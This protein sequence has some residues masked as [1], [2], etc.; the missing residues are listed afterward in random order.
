MTPVIK[1]ESFSN[2]SILNNPD[3]SLIQDDLN[4]LHRLNNTTIQK[5]NDMNKLQNYLNQFKD[6]KLAIR[7]DSSLAYSALTEILDKYDISLIADSEFPDHLYQRPY[8]VVDEDAYVYSYKNMDEVYCFRNIYD[9]VDI[10]ELECLDMLQDFKDGKL[11]VQLINSYQYEKFISYLKENGIAI[12]SAMEYTQNPSHF[13]YFYMLRPG[14][15]T[16]GESYK[17]IQDYVHI[18]KLVPLG[19]FMPAFEKTMKEVNKVKEIQPNDFA[20]FTSGRLVVHINNSMEHRLFIDYLKEQGLSSKL[21]PDIRQYNKDKSYF[22]MY[23][24]KMSGEMLLAAAHYIDTPSFKER[25]KDMSVKD[26]CNVDFAN[27]TKI[28]EMK[29]EP[30]ET[31]PF[32]LYE[33]VKA[34]RDI[35]FSQLEALGTSF[36][37]KEDAVKERIEGNVLHYFD[38]LLG[39]KKEEIIFRL[40]HIKGAADQSA[41]LMDEIKKASLETAE[42]LKQER[43]AKSMATSFENADAMLAVLNCGTSLYNL[44]NGKYVWLYSEDGDVAVDN[45]NALI[46]NKIAK[47]AVE[48]SDYWE[49]FLPMGAQIYTKE[50]IKN[51]CEDNCHSAWITSEDYEKTLGLSRD[52]EQNKDTIERD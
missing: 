26:F 43:T 50:E 30:E 5:G 2:H 25:Y 29:A 39:S 35:A 24:G 3:K 10:S 16:A 44:D 34:E 36:G 40:N 38:S 12:N 28:Q 42:W 33:Q 52:M 46:A 41:V 15:L 1:S 7:V 49:V 31:V 11:V 32:S 4:K 21:Y 20:D 48:Q 9:S 51:F 27:N 14:I 23:K 8:V 6:G 19:V 13:P 18:N 47:E 37:E 45:I 22:Y 17:A